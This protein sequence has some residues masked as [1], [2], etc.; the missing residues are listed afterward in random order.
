MQQQSHASFARYA[1]SLRS[2][3]LWEDLSMEATRETEA[4]MVE[5]ADVLHRLCLGWPPDT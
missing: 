2:I 4:A 5:Q 1:S 3:Q